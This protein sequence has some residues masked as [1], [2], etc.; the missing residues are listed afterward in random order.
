MSKKDDTPEESGVV[1]D[2]WLES[3]ARAMLE[4]SIFSIS[5]TRAAIGNYC[6]MVCRISVTLEFFICR[7]CWLR[8]SLRIKRTS[9][10][11]SPCMYCT[12]LNIGGRRHIPTGFK[13]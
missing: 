2:L 11:D 12:D 10:K 6:V 7:C 4:A 8:E 5:T 9:E 1:R 13:P 3:V